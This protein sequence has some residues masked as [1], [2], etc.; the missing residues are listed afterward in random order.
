MAKFSEGFKKQKGISSI[1]GRGGGMGLSGSE[2]PK[3]VSRYRVCLF[4]HVLTTGLLVVRVGGKAGVETIQELLVQ[5][6]VGRISTSLSCW[7]AGRGLVQLGEYPVAALLDQVA[8]HG[9]AEEANLGPLHA[10]RQVLLLLLLQQ[11]IDKYLLQLF[12][13]EVDDELFKAILLE[14]LKSVNV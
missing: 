7:K 13:C 11:T 8:D 14:S 9:V 6:R 10:L 2:L 1:K 4:S 5:Q 12:I 3:R